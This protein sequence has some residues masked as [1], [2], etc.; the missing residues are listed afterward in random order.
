[1]RS[2][3]NKVAVIT[4]AGSGIG[5]ALAVALAQHGAKLAISDINLDRVNDTAKL[6]EKTKVRPYQ[7]DTGNRDAIYHHADDVVRD[8]GCVNLVI[9]NAGVAVT[10]TVQEMTDEDFTWLMN[11]N[12]WGMA[13]GSRAFLPHLIASGGG[14]LV[15][16]SSIFGMVGIPKNA[17]Y[18]ASKF[19]IRGF[20]EALRQEMQMEKQPVGVSCVHPGGISTNIAINGRLGPSE[21]GRDVAA[22]FARVAKTTPEQAAQVILKGIQ[23]N[24][25]RIFIGRDAHLIDIVQ[26]LL[27]SPYEK[28][29]GPQYIKRVN[30]K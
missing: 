9:N 14:H 30:G 18:N 5:R 10:A 17:A 12:F 1:M 21:A 20:T 28:I 27:G 24:R 7:V 13:H 16:I 3:H 29:V 19:A 4:G 26:R 11:I 15:N 22:S 2:F 8:F 23:K 25:G 6:C